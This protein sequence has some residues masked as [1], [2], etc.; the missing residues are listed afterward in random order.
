MKSKS[1]NEKEL[2]NARLH[3]FAIVT[4]IAATLLIIAGALVTSTGSGDSVPDWPLAYGSLTPPMVGGIVFEYSH[5][6]IAGMTATLVGILA[7]WL[8]FSRPRRKI[9]WLGLAAFL[10]VLA[11]AVLGGL[12]V[13]VV[14]N[15]AVRQ[16]V[17]FFIGSMNFDSYRLF[18]AT[19]HGILGQT[20]LFLLFSITLF[21]SESWIKSQ[22][23]GKEIRL[24]PGARGMSLL[25]FGAVFIQLCLGTLIRHADASLVIPDFPLAFGRIIPPFYLP[26]YGRR[27]CFPG[28]AAVL[29]PGDGADHTG[30]G[31][32]FLYYLP[33]DFPDRQYCQ[34]IVWPGAD[35]GD[36]GGLQYLGENPGLYHSPPC[37]G[38]RFDPGQ[39]RG[40]DPVGV[41]LSAGSGSD[42]VPCKKD[43]C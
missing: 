17:G 6:L 31:G 34:N 19:A 4:S 23:N 13:M 18:F 8:W 33:E 41:A 7:I 30:T 42:P 22:Q 39:Q 35:S 11:Q 3:Y 21:L 27:F 1:V 16:F 5:R 32:L 2:Y 24:A 38:W 40:S 25:L 37:S 28:G 29:P 20:V 36:P 26:G 15:E 12:R 10:A 9:R 14:S 43:A